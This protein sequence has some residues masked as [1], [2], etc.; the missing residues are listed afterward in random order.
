MCQVLEIFLIRF[1]A[2]LHK[3]QPSRSIVILFT[4]TNVSFPI[5]KMSDD[6]ILNV[7]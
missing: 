1:S 3:E 2:S 4:V 7:L 5:L 6:V